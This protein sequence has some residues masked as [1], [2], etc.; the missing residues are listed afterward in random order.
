M[1]DAHGKSQVFATIKGQPN[2]LS[3]YIDPPLPKQ[4][5]SVLA[6]DVVDGTAAAALKVAQWLI[7]ADC[8]VD[9]A[10][11]GGNSPLH[12]AVAGGMLEFSKFLVS[13][14]ADPNRSNREGRTPLHYACAYGHA[15]VAEVLV[16]A[17]ASLEKSDKFG[18]TPRQIVE[19]PGPILAVDALKY[20]NLARLCR[21]WL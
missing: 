18:T 9:L 4:S 13:Q 2:W 15:A 12:H 8:A 3:S 19:G 5:H 10:D 16:K 6:R 17:G 20:L 7:R 1:A 21:P 14:G 11:S